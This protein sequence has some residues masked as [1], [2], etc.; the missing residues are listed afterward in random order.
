MFTPAVAK[1]AVF[2]DWIVEGDTEVAVGVGG[3]VEGMPEVVLEEKA[4]S[5]VEGMVTMGV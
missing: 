5:L 4:A 3:T 2:I 1:L